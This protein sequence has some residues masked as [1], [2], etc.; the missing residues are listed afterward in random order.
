MARR[1]AEER[2]SVKVESCSSPDLE[3]NLFAA[4]LTMASSSP[5]L[6]MADARCGR[7]QC[8]APA[9]LSLTA[10]HAP[11][12]PTRRAPRD[13]RCCWH[14][15]QRARDSGA[16]AYSHR[17]Q[18]RRLTRQRCRNRRS[19]TF[20]SILSIRT[21]RSDGYVPYWPKGRKTTFAGFGLIRTQGLRS[22]F[23]S[24]SV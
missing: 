13:A 11:A 8:Q 16:G 2:T 7:Q 4:V 20:I 24:P 12:K 19:I 21:R 6:T 23:A 10:P 22:Y 5:T 9:D 3:K 15:T 18:A 1:P 17:G 14:N